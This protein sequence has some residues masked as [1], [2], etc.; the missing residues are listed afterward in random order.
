MFQRDTRNQILRALGADNLLDNL[1]RHAMM[2]HIL[3]KLEY[4]FSK[5][6]TMQEWKMETDADFPLFGSIIV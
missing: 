3:F 1:K 5:S 4:L 2:R 6:S